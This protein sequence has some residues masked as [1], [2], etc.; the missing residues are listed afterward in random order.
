MQHPSSGR[1]GIPRRLIPASLALAA[2]PLSGALAQDGLVHKLDGPHAGAQLGRS[3][4]RLGDVDG[5]GVVDVLVGA[6]SPI[7]T[8]VL[9]P[10]ARLYSGATGQLLHEHSSPLQ[11]TQGWFGA[12]VGSAGDVDGDGV[13]DYGIGEPFR[14]HVHVYSGQTR[15][16]LYSVP[17]FG[18]SDQFGV[19]LA[20]LGD[21]NGDGV[22]DLAGGGAA[23]VRVFSGVDGTLIHLLQNGSSSTEFGRSLAGIG[24]V[25][26][27]GVPDLA[28]GA[29]K[30]GDLSGGI[31]GYQ[32]GRVAVFSGNDGSVLYA[33]DGLHGSG[34]FGRSIV[35]LDDQDLD[36]I[37]E[38]AVGAVFGGPGGRGEVTVHSGATGA[39]LRQISGPLTSGTYFGGALGNAGDLDGDSS[40][41]LLVGAHSLGDGAPQGGGVLIYSTA[42]GALLEMVVGTEPSGHFGFSVAGLGDLDGDGAVEL[43]AGAPGLGNS[44]PG[45]AGIYSL[46]ADSM[47]LV[48]PVEAPVVPAPGAPPALQ[49]IGEIAVQADVGAAIEAAFT[50]EPEFVPL[51][52]C[53][54]FR[55]IN[56]V[57]RFTQNGV[58]QTTDPVVGLVP[59]IDPA[60]AVDPRPFYYTDSEWAQGLFGP[61]SIHAEGIHSVFV[62]VPS[63]SGDEVVE[64]HTFLVARDTAHL[65]TPEHGFLPLAGFRWRYRALTDDSLI[66]GPVGPQAFELIDAA[67][68]QGL[69][70]GHVGSPGFPGWGAVAGAAIQS[71]LQMCGDVEV[72]DLTT[73]QSLTL[74]FG[75]E[76]AGSPYYV[77]GSASGTSPGI[78]LGSETLPLVLDAYTSASFIDP[79][80]VGLGSSS[81]LVP[82]SG[83]GSAAFSVPAT[84]GVAAV[85][86]TLHH[87]WVVQLS[88]IHI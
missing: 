38:F 83:T 42:D 84:A 28:V 37:P 87:A 43:V 26:G 59:A 7:G 46:C 1:P 69:I 70:S 9:P 58:D 81:G 56:V 34:F 10:L 72:V 13:D 76:H 14:S 64:F 82:P 65:A 3:V 6:P 67:L 12:S 16:L 78:S 11:E 71:H 40:D 73:A 66:C 8:T 25:N 33:V 85:G 77:V 41:D 57:S 21:V 35:A 50:F 23:S 17:G 29:A 20:S 49:K 63:S 53:N 51:D 88:L 75:A 5:D 15:T 80:S 36:G 24:D 44:D 62:D 61:D 22:P 54:D 60:P 68:A 48:L 30:H 45:F 4:A 27:D 74:R 55:W 19:A 86:L 79:G 31:A 18:G 47:Q 52:G 32:V 2:L 39:L